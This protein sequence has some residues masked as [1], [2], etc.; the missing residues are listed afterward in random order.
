M[1]VPLLSQIRARPLWCSGG[2][3]LLLGIIAACLTNPTPADYQRHTA[4]EINTFLLTQVCPEI[5][6]RNSG[7]AM[8]ALEVCDQLESRP[9]EEIER[10]IAYNTQ[11]YNLGVATLF[12]TELPIQTIWS[13]G[14]FG[15][16]I[17]LRL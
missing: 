9:A 17:P 6:N 16:I 8:V 5:I 7:I 14:L 15:Q 13:L 12:V 1:K 2:A 11:A 10:Y 4:T 3:F